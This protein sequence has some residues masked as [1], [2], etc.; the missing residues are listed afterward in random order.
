MQRRPENSDSRQKVSRARPRGR[1]RKEGV[2]LTG[3][4][5]SPWNSRRTENQGLAG[6]SPSRGE[7]A[8]SDCHDGE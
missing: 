7:G 5:P 1:G 2:T 4:T 6:R 3:D 8:G